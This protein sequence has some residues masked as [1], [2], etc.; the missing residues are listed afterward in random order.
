MQLRQ[1]LTAQSAHVRENK[2][3]SLCLISLDKGQKQ[4]MLPAER[5]IC[6]PNKSHGWI[7]NLSVP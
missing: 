3:F 6:P 4:L 1:A 7:G 5:Q 2:I